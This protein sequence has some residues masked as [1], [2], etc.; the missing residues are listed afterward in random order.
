[1]VVPGIFLIVDSPQ[2]IR[3][4][5]ASIR[6]C[7]K[8]LEKWLESVLDG[9]IRVYH[10]AIYG[11]FK[12]FLFSPLAGEMIQLFNSFQTGWNHQ[13]VWKCMELYGLPGLPF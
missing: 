8:R 13:L 1:M 9:E 12:C 5:G 2:P 11:G 10:F 4:C 6:R 3:I 7:D